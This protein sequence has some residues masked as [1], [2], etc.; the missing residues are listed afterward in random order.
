VLIHF[1]QV[2]HHASLAP[3]SIGL[4]DVNAFA[5]LTLALLTGAYVILTARIANRAAASVDAAKVAASAS[6]SAALSASR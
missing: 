5:T 3:A 1:A 6:Q 4:N 2:H